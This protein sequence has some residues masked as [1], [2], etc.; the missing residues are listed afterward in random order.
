MPD[1]NKLQALRDSGFSVQPSC[2]LCEHFTARPGML[3]GNCEVTTCDHLKHSE[4]GKAASVP[5][6]G[7]CP[8]FIRRE[9]G[10]NLRGH[11]EFWRDER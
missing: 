9:N 3:W 2:M 5:S 8:S 6:C 10:L 4:K 11:E 1:E 7:S